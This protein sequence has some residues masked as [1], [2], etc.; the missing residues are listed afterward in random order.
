VTTLCLAAALWGLDLEEVWQRLSGLNYRTLPVILSLL[1]LF[2]WLKAIRWRLLLSPLRKFRTQEVIPSLMIG[3]MGNNILP[4]HLG[5]VI[6]VFVLGRK[7]TLSKTAVFSSVVLER[8]LDM[9]VI[10]IFVGVGLLVVEGLPPW[11]QTGALTVAVLGI[12]FSFLLIAF[13]FRTQAFV[14]AYRKVF[15]FLPTKLF[16]QLDKIMGSTAQGLASIKNARTAFWIT[17][18]SLLQWTVMGGMVYVSLVSLG[19][20][21]NPLASIVTTGVSALGAA[22]PSTPGYFGVIQLSFWLSLQM[23]GVNKADAF[24]SSVYF[25]LSQYIP[26]TLVGLYYANQLGLRLKEIKESVTEKKE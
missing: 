25:H 16:H 11:V 20:W 9:L 3:F 23:F 17:L 19:L 1:V 12:S 24:A 22:V 15:H 10:L 7:F 6:R 21:L 4:A 8:V 5:E 18:T 14:Q 26:V 13:V 2:F